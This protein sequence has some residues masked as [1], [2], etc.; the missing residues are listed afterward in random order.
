MLYDQLSGGQQTA[1]K[2]LPG[3]M[4]VPESLV[5]NLHKAS[6][7][8]QLA[9]EKQELGSCPRLEAGEGDPS[10]GVTSFTVHSSLFSSRNINFYCFHFFFPPLGINS[11]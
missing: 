5:C 6:T 10:E 3:P 9:W 1:K 8:A 4:C 11:S 2:R 7:S